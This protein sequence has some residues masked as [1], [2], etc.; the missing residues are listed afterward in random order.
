LHAS[1]INSAVGWDV[2]GLIIKMRF[3]RLDIDHNPSM[4]GNTSRGSRGAKNLPRAGNNL[5]PLW[6]SVT[7]QPFPITHWK[8]A[9]QA[10]C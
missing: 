8:S 7:A 9:L 6:P 4:S 10:R 5:T 3:L 2:F 1:S